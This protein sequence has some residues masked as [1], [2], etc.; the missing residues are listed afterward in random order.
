[1]ALSP[2]LSEA[3]A[4]RKHKPASSAALLHQVGDP[5]GILPTLRAQGADNALAPVLGLVLAQLPLA[6]D[7]GNVDA[8]PDDAPEHALVVF[9]RAQ[10]PR[11]R[12][13]LFKEGN[14]VAD[15]LRQG[16]LVVDGAERPAG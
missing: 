6:L 15:D 1:M 4:Q 9:A 5:F 2:I 7:A 10:L 13:A 16:A 14:A 8:K 11:L 3:P 12:P